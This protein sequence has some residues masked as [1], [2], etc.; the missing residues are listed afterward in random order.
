MLN[1]TQTVR[2]FAAPVLFGSAQSGCDV[3]TFVDTAT[4]FTAGASKRAPA[5]APADGMLPGVVVQVIPH[6]GTTARWQ[7]TDK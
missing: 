1:T 2:A 3:Q 7:R 4:I 5:V 6:R